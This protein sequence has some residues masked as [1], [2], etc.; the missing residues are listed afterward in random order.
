MADKFDK[1]VSNKIKDSLEHHAIPYDP[2]SW[3]KLK[4]KKNKKKRLGFWY[5]RVASVLVVMLL[6][7]LFVNYFVDVN[8]DEKNFKQKVN[9]EELIPS[10]T[11]DSLQT[12]PQKFVAESVDSLVNKTNSINKLEDSYKKPESNKIQ[13]NIAINKIVDTTKKLEIGLNLESENTE[14]VSKT[15]HE[16]TESNLTTE[17]KDSLVNNKKIVKKPT[18][19]ILDKINLLEENT[20]IVDKSHIDK[21]LKLGVLISSL[22]NVQDNKSSNDMAISSGLSLEIPISNKFELFVGAIYSNQNF[23]VLSQSNT[24]SGA[25][26][27]KGN[28]IILK[29]RA[30]SVSAVEIPFKLK[31]NF[32][33]NKK[34][35]FVSSGISSVQYFNEK[36]EN[37]FVKNERSKITGKDNLGDNF[38]QYELMQTENSIESS[39]DSNKFEL[40][41]TFNISAGILIPIANTNHNLIIEPYFKYSLNTITS[42][43]V[44]YSNVGLH[45]RY[46]FS[47]KK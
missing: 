10:S 30:T 9:K 46:N 36:V 18:D 14:A 39:V 26:R 42:Q 13:N 47:F 38:V 20:I 12:S 17:K 21:R 29:S 16:T 11:K 23:N 5:W 24:L 40:F 37:T 1:I 41:G 3:E 6:T 44:N 15:A 31:Y 8:D 4:A 22:Y 32:K 2:K 7:S 19:S 33:I 25:I 45:F 28:N 27:A 35:L 43:N 34:Y